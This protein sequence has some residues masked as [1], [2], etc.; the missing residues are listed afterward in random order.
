VY[1]AKSSGSLPLKDLLC[2]LAAKPLDHGLIITR[3]DNIVKRYY[4]CLTLF[5][6]AG[7]TGAALA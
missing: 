6:A 2:V 1:S 3:H 4:V 5:S 7:R